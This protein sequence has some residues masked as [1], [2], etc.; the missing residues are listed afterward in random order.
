MKNRNDTL[1]DEKYERIKWFSECLNYWIAH[2]GR[3]G[4]SLAAYPCNLIN[5]QIMA[6]AIKKFGKAK[7]IVNINF[8]GAI[9]FAQDGKEIK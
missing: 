4:S 5:F 1:S 7:E 9:P 3:S 6:T 8:G 2:T